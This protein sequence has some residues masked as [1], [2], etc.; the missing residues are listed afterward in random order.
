MQ[1]LEQEDQ[2]RRDEEA[3]YEAKREAAR[4]TAKLRN[5][6]QAKRDAAAAAADNWAPADEWEM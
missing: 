1:L 6:E 4:V 2:L 3:F 5:D